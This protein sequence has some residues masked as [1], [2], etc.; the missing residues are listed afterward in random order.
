MASI[1]RETET[2][3]EREIRLTA[4]RALKNASKTKQH[5]K[6]TRLIL[7]HMERGASFSSPKSSRLLANAGQLVSTL[8]FW[9]FPIF[10]PA[11]LSNKWI[12]CGELRALLVCHASSSK[13]DEYGPSSPRGMNQRQPRQAV[14]GCMRISFYT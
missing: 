4:A 7:P 6:R 12:S 3:R 14:Q 2:D 13:T 8:L 11:A 5:N 1:G 9:G 10:S